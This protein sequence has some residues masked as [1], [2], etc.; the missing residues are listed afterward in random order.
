MAKKP[1]SVV[2]EVQSLRHVLKQE[3]KPEEK[4]VKNGEKHK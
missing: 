1:K 3:I 4:E 2:L